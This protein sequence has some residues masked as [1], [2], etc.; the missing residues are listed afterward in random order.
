MELWGFENNISFVQTTGDL[1]TTGA[2]NSPTLPP[3]GSGQ[4]SSTPGTSAN[5]TGL[6]QSLSNMSRNAG[7]N[8]S[9][10]GI[11][12]A[13]NS[14]NYEANVTQNPDGTRS[15]Q[16]YNAGSAGGDI[17]GGVA[18]GAQIGGA[19]GPIGAAIGAIV[20]AV[21]GGVTAITKGARTGSQAREVAAHNARIQSE[22][23]NAAN[24]Q[25]VAQMMGIDR[26]PDAVPV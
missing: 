4:P 11:A 10:S 21:A 5:T 7:G 3:A 2:T 20:G 16:R 14:F 12:G 17:F 1:Q 9:A 13:F 26:M 22:Q 8:S 19:L 23:M 18:Q 15:I 25:Q 24:E 6:P